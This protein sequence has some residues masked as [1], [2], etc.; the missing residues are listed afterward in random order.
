MKAR[1][2]GTFLE[3]GGLFFNMARVVEGTITDNEV[4]LYFLPRIDDPG[5][6]FPVILRGEMREAFLDW[7]E[8]QAELTTFSPFR[9]PTP[10][11]CCS[12]IGGGTG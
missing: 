12:P 4:H 6:E 10:S 5:E 2:V 9:I 11:T 1:S 8:N 7:W 3:I